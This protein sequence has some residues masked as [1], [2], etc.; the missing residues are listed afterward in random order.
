MNG[1]PVREVRVGSAL[2][3]DVVHFYRQKPESLEAT[4]DMLDDLYSTLAN[5]MQT[6]RGEI[7]KWLGDGALACFW[8]DDHAERAVRAAVALHEE[9]EAFA[10]R[11]GFSDSGLT[12]SVA[13]GEMIHGE[14][15]T[16]TARH[17]D[18]FGEP[19]NC[20]ATIM[21]E[22]SGAIT[23]CEATYE[24]VSGFVE[25]EKLVEHEYYGPLFALTGT[26][27]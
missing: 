21:P 12:I 20:T 6:H 8:G 5:T 22:A 26:Q 4:A 16:G 18:V 10:G 11:H 7:V 17:E 24:A 1:I 23:L 15:G 25:A 14:F 2:I 9:F 19:V 27:G 13:S 3:A